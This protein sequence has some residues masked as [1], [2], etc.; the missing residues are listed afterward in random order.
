MG[1]RHLSRTQ[2]ER[3]AKEEKKRAATAF[4]SSSSDIL[5]EMR[6][7]LREAEKRIAD[8]RKEIEK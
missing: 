6:K 3:L 7:L 5:T 1:G 8:T 4:L 2:A